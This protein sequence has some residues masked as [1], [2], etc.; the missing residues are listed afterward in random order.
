MLD[1]GRKTHHVRVAVLVVLT[2]LL[3]LAGLRLTKPL[4]IASTT[5]AGAGS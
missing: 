1:I 2:S 4:A 3:V 5:H